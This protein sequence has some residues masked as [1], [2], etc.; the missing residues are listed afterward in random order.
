MRDALNYSHPKASLLVCKI[1]KVIDKI[2]P[3]NFAFA[4]Q[5]SI[6]SNLYLATANDSYFAGCFDSK[7][8]HI[9]QTFTNSAVRK[10]KFASSSIRTQYIA[11]CTEALAQ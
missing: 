3:N 2:G 11:L 1:I 8:V 4:L 6:C 10:S 5:K 9:C 7:L